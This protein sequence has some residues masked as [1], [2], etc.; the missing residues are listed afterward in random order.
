MKE[1]ELVQRYLD[2]GKKAQKVGLTLG[3]KVNDTFGFGDIPGAAGLVLFDTLENVE[4][5]LNGY[6][7]GYFSSGKHDI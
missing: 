7:Y 5:F 6:T 3:I 4:T 2:L 1:A